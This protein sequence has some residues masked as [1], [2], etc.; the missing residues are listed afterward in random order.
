MDR[1]AHVNN[2]AFMKYVQAARVNFWERT[3]INGGFVPKDGKGPTLASTACQ[4]K[5]QLLYPGQVMVRTRC[6]FIKTTSF[7]LEHHL[8][9]SFG[10]VCAEAQDVIVWFDYDREEKAPIP[11]EM[12]AILTELKD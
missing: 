7:G 5:A 2:V 11:E 6:T 12:R 3:G 9:N 8:L 1:F 10:A 4:F